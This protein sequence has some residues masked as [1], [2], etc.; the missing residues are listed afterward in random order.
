MELK[1]S[2]EQKFDTEVGNSKMT[3]VSGWRFRTC[4]LLPTGSVLGIASL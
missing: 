4:N 3:R 1:T 2:M